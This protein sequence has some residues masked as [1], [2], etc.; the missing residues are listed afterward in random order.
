MLSRSKIRRIWWISFHIDGCGTLRT[1]ALRR[2]IFKQ[3]KGS[4]HSLSRDTVPL[5]TSLIGISNTV[6]RGI[7]L[8]KHQEASKSRYIIYIINYIWLLKVLNDKEWS[9]GEVKFP[10]IWNNVDKKKKTTVIYRIPPHFFPS[11]T[12]FQVLH[13]EIHCIV[14]HYVTTEDIF[15]EGAPAADE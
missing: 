1:V 10:S 15:L 12:I 8:I 6:V 9:V 7:R 5:K 14:L 4:S 3:K 13:N 2:P 11:T